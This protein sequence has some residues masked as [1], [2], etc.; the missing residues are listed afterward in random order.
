ML[1][2]VNVA[3][4]KCSVMQWLVGYRLRSERPLSSTSH[5]TEPNVRRSCFA[6][7]E[8]PQRSHSSRRLTGR[9]PNRQ[10]PQSTASSARCVADGK[11]SLAMR[12]PPKPASSPSPHKSANGATHTSEGRSPSYGRRNAGGLKARPM[13]RSLIV[14]TLSSE[15]VSRSQLDSRF[16]RT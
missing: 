9:S 13:A 2:H 4:C 3:S 10:P 5:K 8:P 12:T 7:T 14:I 6:R 11:I 15:L 1:P 16:P